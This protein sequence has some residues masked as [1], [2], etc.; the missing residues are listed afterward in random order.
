MLVNVIDKPDRVELLAS[1]DFDFASCKDFLGFDCKA[2]GKD[3]HTDFD[4]VAADFVFHDL[5]LVASAV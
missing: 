4:I 1:K 5:P 3:C 2:V